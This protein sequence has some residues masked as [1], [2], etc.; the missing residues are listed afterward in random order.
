MAALFGN[1][2]NHP[3]LGEILSVGSAL[4]WAVSV[5]LFRV[6]GRTVPPLALNLFKNVLAGGMLLLTMAAIK[7][8]I[9]IKSSLQNYS[10]LAASGIIGIALSDTLFFAC[11]NRLGAGLTAII[12]CL[13]SPFVICLSL[14][15]LDEK[16]RGIQLFG[17][18]LIITAVL[19]VSQ[20]KHR[21]ILSRRDLISG[22]F[23]GIS[24]MLALAVGIVLIK[25]I[26]GGVPVLWASLIR[27]GSGAAT[28]GLLLLA[29]PQG[30]AMAKP[31][32]SSKNW[33]TM[34]PASLLG[35]Y[36]GIITWMGGMKFTQASVAAPLNQLSTIFIFILAVV[37]LK[38]E[39]TA[40]KV[41]AVILGFAG[42]VLASLRPWLF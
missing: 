36:I 28:L 9:L 15:F 18:F 24:A 2:Q 22:I 12:N 16:M 8:P 30:L 37:F 42:A 17:V 41:M 7:E 6:S 23:L 1:L 39:A 34:V 14:L 13:Y 3:Y 33:Q 25:P 35:G 10:L 11:L 21:E 31:L 19:L 5:I 26:L 20:K 32:L 4:A 29:H 38:E 27:M 40:K